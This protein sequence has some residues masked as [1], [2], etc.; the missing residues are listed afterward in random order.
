LT[1][2]DS[3]FTDENILVWVISTVSLAHL[4]IAPKIACST[5]RIAFL[6]KGEHKKEPD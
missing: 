1:I 4:T 2:A 6:G 3:C 5:W